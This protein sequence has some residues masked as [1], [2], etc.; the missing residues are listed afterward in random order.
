[1]T[2]RLLRLLALFALA[3][4]WINTSRNATNGD[5]LA[6]RFVVM[7][8]QIAALNAFMAQINATSTDVVSASES[9]T[10][11]TF[12]DLSTPGPSVT[13][14]IGISGEALLTLQAF[15]S[16]TSNPLGVTAQIGISI[17]GGAAYTVLEMSN[18]ANNANEITLSGSN[19]ATGLTTGSHTFKMQYAVSSGNSCTFATRQL[20]AVPL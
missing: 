19:L 5:A 9:T 18:D 8:N 15:T 14:N 13:V 4:P 2:R 10:S 6:R 16:P 12:T 1:V 11:S 7:Q 17:D 20:T 3:S